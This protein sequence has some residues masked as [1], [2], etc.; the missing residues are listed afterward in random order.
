MSVLLRA[1]DGRELE[2]DNCDAGYL[3][4]SVEVSAPE[5]RAVVDPRPMADGVM[6]RTKYVGAR[7]ITVTM[8][9]MEGPSSRRALLDAIG[10]FLHPGQ[11]STL[12]I[13]AHTWDS[14]RLYHVRADDWSAPWENTYALAVAL[15]FRTSSVS[16][17]GQSPEEHSATIT[18]SASED[19]GR[20]YYESLVPAGGGVPADTWT[21]E[22]DREYPYTGLVQVPIVNHGDV[23]TPWVAKV[24][25]PI[26]GFT[27]V[28]TTI[29][30]QLAF[31][32][33]VVPAG[34]HVLIDSAAHTVLADGDPGSSRYHFLNFATATWFDLVPG[35]NV[36]R[37]VSTT[38]SAPSQTV[39]TWRDAY[40]S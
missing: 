22:Y 25:G 30:E 11:R 39:M 40:M 16:P 31:P 4:E 32:T 9:L 13:H 23:P 6:D 14:P 33:L 10:P 26:Q 15:S 18:P 37:V 21:R 5:V 17:F 36:M 35:P 8:N 29:E 1:P 7:A 19:L 3:V 12:T 28:N 34:Q 24:Y 20:D 2:L 27:L 38:Y